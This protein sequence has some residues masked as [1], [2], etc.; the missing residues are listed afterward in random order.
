[1]PCQQGSLDLQIFR[2]DTWSNPR[3]PFIQLKVVFF[4]DFFFAFLS[5][6]TF[7]ITIQSRYVLQLILSQPSKITAFPSTQQ[8]ER[9]NPYD[10][11]SSHRRGNILFTISVLGLEIMFMAPFVLP[12]PFSLHKKEPVQSN[13]YHHVLCRSLY[14]IA[15]TLVR[16]SWWERCH[17][18]WA[19]LLS[20]PCSF[21]MTCWYYFLFLP[22]LLYYYSWNWYVLSNSLCFLTI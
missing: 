3:F 1:M 17:V 8:F 19:N 6:L 5:P 9:G 14:L 18:C 11:P 2:E 21:C 12:I 20:L 13:R 7:F 16:P 22:Q 15:N 4:H 10:N